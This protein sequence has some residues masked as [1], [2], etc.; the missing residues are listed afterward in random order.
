MV[1]H[2]I[3][4]P[5]ESQIRELDSRVLLACCAAKTGRSVVLGSTSAFNANLW[6]LPRGVLFWKAMT[7]GSLSSMKAA[8]RYGHVN[9]AWD[10]EAP[11]HYSPDMYYP[12]R[13][14]FRTLPLISRIFAWGQENIDLWSGHGAF[15]MHLVF[16]T[17]NP[18]ADLLTPKLR[19][20]F[21]D[22]VAALK[23]EHGNFV[24][25]N[26]NFG[27]VNCDL[28]S[29]NL[30][31]KGPDGALLYGATSKGLPEQQVDRLF[32]YRSEIFGSFQ[33]LIP[34]IAR[35]R[36]TTTFILRPHFAESLDFW[37]QMLKD[38]PNVKVLRHGNVVPWL[39]AATAII[40]NG[41]TTAVEAYALN[42]PAIAFECSRNPEFDV[43]LPNGLSKR[44]G[45]AKEVVA[46]ISKIEAGHRNRRSVQRD[47]LFHYHVHD[48]TQQL[49]SEI[50][51]DQ[52]NK[53]AFPQNQASSTI[54]R[55]ISRLMVKLKV[56]NRGIKSE[57]QKHKEMKFPPLDLELVKR[58]AETFSK[59]LITPEPKIS[60]DGSGL[61]SFVPGG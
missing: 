3:Y 24:L 4:L 56:V 53:I 54:L 27:N 41:C 51:L 34:Q 30:K 29:L 50:I 32:N 17:G 46:E 9:V 31:Y 43:E 45:T 15:P 40:H 38:I 2:P 21:A 47:K 37:E 61:I 5:M 60:V 19:T 36:P 16:L 35:A 8:K 18:R 55:A 23:K 59:L 7:R 12:R 44:C 13:I 10:E 39:C 49:A 58:K 48:T 25:V 14:D 22:D 11:V 20:A 26:T 6:R 42:I 1:G 33:E 52:I 57:R 28:P